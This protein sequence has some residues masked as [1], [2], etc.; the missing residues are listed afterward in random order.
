VAGAEKDHDAIVGLRELEQ[1]GADQKIAVIP[2][3]SQVGARLIATLAYA[4]Y[5]AVARVIRRESRRIVQEP[6]IRGDAFFCEE[7]GF[8]IDVA[9]GRG[10]LF[11]EKL[12]EA[13]RF[14]EILEPFVGEVAIRVQ[15]IDSRAG[16]L[17]QAEA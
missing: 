6:E 16:A 4:K 3:G 17:G 7:P 1:I 10:V 8:L 2:G 11:V 14:G 12:A 13:A 5:V 9:L 15:A